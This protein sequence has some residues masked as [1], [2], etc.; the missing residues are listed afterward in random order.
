MCLWFAA[1]LLACFGVPRQ[2]IASAEV[3]GQGPA[4]GSSIIGAV[5]LI[6]MLLLQ[7]A[8]YSLQGSSS[9]LVKFFRTPI[10][11]IKQPAVP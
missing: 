9:V 2:V 1:V 7:V 11:V 10:T 4:T 6:G 5:A 8:I 3:Q